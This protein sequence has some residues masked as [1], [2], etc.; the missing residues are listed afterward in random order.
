MTAKEALRQIIDTLSEEAAE[1]LLD[2]LNMRADPDTLTDDEITELK[3][4][5][6]EIACGDYLTLE[7]IQ[8]RV[9]PQ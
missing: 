6:A 4:A 2:Y 9:N 7:E 1:D 8:R 5:E 3:A